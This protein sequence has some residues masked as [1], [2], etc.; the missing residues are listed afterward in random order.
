V[1]ELERVCDFLIDRNLPI[2]WEGQGIP[3][4][5]MTPPLV[6]KMKASGCR[7]I[8]WGLESGSDT[9]LA[10]CRKGQIFSVN[11]AEQ[12][13]R[14]SHESGIDTEVFIMVGLPGEDDKE[15]AKTED[16]IHRNHTYIDRIKSVNTVHLVHGTEL[17]THANEYGLCLPTDNWHYLWYSEDG[18][19]DYSQRLDRARSIIKLATSLGIEV[20]EHNLFEGKEEELA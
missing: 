20:M 4:R 15:F 13:I 14:C 12:V 3:Y 18:G 1:K 9:V 16:F 10:K 5:K 6:R 19:N 2:A 8:Q 11:D 7:K 17:L